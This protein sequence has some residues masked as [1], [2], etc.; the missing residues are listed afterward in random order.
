MTLQ[1]EA[2]CNRLRDWFDEG[3]ELPGYRREYGKP[4]LIWLMGLN[5]SFLKDYRAGD[6]YNYLQDHM[7]EEQC[8]N[9]LGPHGWT[10]YKMMLIR[11]EET[12]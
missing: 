3:K 4:H 11:R 8:N 5:D 6:T 1:I 12:K 10:V 7:T 2:L 9:L